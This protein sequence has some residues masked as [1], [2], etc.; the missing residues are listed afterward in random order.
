MADPKKDIKD[1]EKELNALKAKLDQTTSD[2][3]S[4]LIKNLKAGGASLSEWN[5]LL[6][7][8]STKADSLADDLDYVSK[9]LTDS[10][11][12][13]IRGNEYINQQI[14]ST[15]KLGSIANDLLSMR[16]GESTYDL[17]K[18]KSLEEQAK[19]QRQIL[20][21]Q[22][23]QFVGSQ[24]DLDALKDKIGVADDLLISFTQITEEA[25]KFQKSMG[26]TGGILKGMSKIPILGNMLGTQEALEAAE[27]A[28]KNG[29]GRLGTMSAAAKSMGKS[30]LSSVSDPVVVMG[31]LL[32]IFKELDDSAEK[33]ARTMN[34]TYKEALQ[35]RNE[36]DAV[37]GITK[38]QMLEAS[39]AINKELGTSA[40]LTQENAAAFAKLQVYAGMTEE[41]LMGITSLSLANGKNIKQNTNE[42][43]AQAKQIVAGKKIV[44][45][46]KQL[47][48]DISKI[49]A[50]TTLSLGKNPKELAKAVA[51]A[52]SLGMEMGKLEDIAGGLLDFESS[53]ENE[54]SAELLTGKDLN[55]EKARQL[56]LN[57]DIAGMAEEINKQ[58]GTSSDYTKMNRIQQEALA[59]SVGMNREEL[60]QTLY[61]Q[62]QIKGL[63]GKEAE[64]RQALLDQRI[65]EVGLAQ[66]KREMED[67]SFNKLKEQSGIQTEF[68]QQILELK[69]TLATGILPIF[70]T[71]AGFIHDHMNMVKIIAAVYLGMK[72]TLGVM[73]ALNMVGLAIDRKRKK[74]A[75][76]EASIEIIGSAAKIG[77]SFGPLGIA[78]AAGIVATG[79]AALAMF[80]GDDV[81]SPGGSGGGYGSRTLFGPEGAIQLNNKDT[82]IAGTNLFD[83][84]DDMTSS[85]K[86]SLQIASN[87]SSN[88]SDMK[89]LKDAMIAMANR[90]VNVGIDGEKVLKATTGK[91][92]NT[93]GDEVGKNSYKIQ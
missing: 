75:E 68:N 84:A 86:G 5:T 33:Y 76:K 36:M 20:R 38:G 37:A 79:L 60:A 87:N 30:L 10:V 16:K 4:K 61:T 15:R 50:A 65:E 77:G 78:I 63:T 54:L 69:D 45:N 80:Q 70:K 67:G 58:I 7:A 89:D 26:I 57:N 41:D 34:I 19:K 18:I 11:N 82:V 49:S 44:L 52:K 53:I 9:S 46:E 59:K 72:V 64:E 31:T 83:K 74:T 3:L 73:N 85:P 23:D 8:F 21:S 55:L 66:A 39:M 48:A 17:K 24:K 43:I 28:A 22:L 47:L 40:Q 56:A 90:P 81:M 93:Y 35:V 27:E 12:E 42:F 71:I 29:A 51:T 25:R 91:Y 32:S 1:I 88:S 6:D 2:S 92:S 13:L 14:K 62:E